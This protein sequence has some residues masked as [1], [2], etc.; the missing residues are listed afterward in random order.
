MQAMFIFYTH[1]QPPAKDIQGIDN[2]KLAAPWEVS[3][4]L[5]ISRLSLTVPSSST[6]YSLSYVNI[7]ILRITP[8]VLWHLQHN[9][10][11]WIWVF[12]IIDQILWPWDGLLVQF[13]VYEW[14]YLLNAWDT[15]A[16]IQYYTEE[17][18]TFLPLYNLRRLRNTASFCENCQE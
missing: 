10:E 13:F 1:I 12:R 5:Q 15:P 7:E 2:K 14:V 17:K 8:Q 18:K 4:Q 6:N 16:T 11:F 3:Y 9:R